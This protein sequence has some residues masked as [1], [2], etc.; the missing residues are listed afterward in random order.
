MPLRHGRSMAIRYTYD[1]MRAHLMCTQ[2]VLMLMAV[3]VSRIRVGVCDVCRG[4]GV[5]LPAHI[6][7]VTVAAV[8]VNCKWHCIQG[9][10]RLILGG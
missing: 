3:R 1:Q 5:V 7:A 4:W 9:C 2:N 10:W 8:D 6:T